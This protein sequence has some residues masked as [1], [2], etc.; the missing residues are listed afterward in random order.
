MSDKLPVQNALANTL[1]DLIFFVDD[2]EFDLRMAQSFIITINREWAGIDRWSVGGGGGGGLSITLTQHNTT[3]QDNTR[4][5]LTP[6]LTPTLS[7]GAWLCLALPCL[8]LSKQNKRVLTL[9]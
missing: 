5:D 8:A 3:P 7:M 6:T 2:F 9:R 1:S 4:Q